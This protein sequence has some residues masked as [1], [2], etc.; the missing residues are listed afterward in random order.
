MI[1]R[2][3]W[4]Q[5]KFN[6]WGVQMITKLSEEV[7]NP[8]HIPKKSQNRLFPMPTLST[9]LCHIISILQPNLSTT[10]N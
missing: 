4:H 2:G 10:H 9:V 7:G 5:S 6:Q 1:K 3:K 8:K